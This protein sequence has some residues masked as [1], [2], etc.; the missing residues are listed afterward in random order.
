MRNR[1]LHDALRDFALEAAAL[2]TEDVNAGAEIEFDVVDDG[3]GRGRSGAALYRYEPRTRSFVA[4]R[5]PRLRVL[6]TCVRAAE[7]LGD[8]LFLGRLVPYK[9][10]ELAISACAWLDRPLKVIGG[11]RGES[12][13]D[14]Q[15]GPRTEFLGHVD[16]RALPGLLAGARALLFPG[17]EDFGMVPVEAQA[18]GVPVIAYGR[19]GARDTVEDGVTGVLYDDPSVGGLTRAI[20][21]FETLSFDEGELRRRAAAFSPER[22]RSELAHLLMTL[23]TELRWSAT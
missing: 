14:A 19:G 11:G 4:E 15:A 21:R 17:E 5:W 22:F 20:E 3:A 10:A 9:R 23:D 7:E 12:G 13:L 2:L 18:A 8:Y 16:D 1:A 6:P